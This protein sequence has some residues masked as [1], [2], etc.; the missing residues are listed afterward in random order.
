MWIA[1]LSHDADAPPCRLCSSNRRIPGGGG[2]WRRLV[3]E[4]GARSGR[5]GPIRVADCPAWRGAQ[6]G[7]RHRR[8]CIMARARGDRCHRGG[9]TALALP[10]TVCAR[11]ANVAPARHASAGTGATGEP[12]QDCQ[13]DA[14]P[15]RAETRSDRSIVQRSGRSALA[16]CADTGKPGPQRRAG[17]KPSPLAIGA[18][19]DGRFFPRNHH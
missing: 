15:A 2:H 18:Q 4:S 6:H 11:R 7:A 3:H 5:G 16:A 13:S 14:G 19:A 8:A 9:T 1:F 12:V 10:H 17:L